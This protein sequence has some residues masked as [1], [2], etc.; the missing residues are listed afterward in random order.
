[1]AQ[2]LPCRQPAKAD[3]A[4]LYE[5]LVGELTD[6]VV[7][8]L[9]PNGCIVSWNPGVERILGYR[10]AEWLGQLADRIFTPEDR[11]GIPQQ[12]MTKAAR[13]G[14]APDVRWHVRKDGERLYVEGT[15]V[16]LRDQGGELLGFSKVMRDVTK[17]QRNEERNALLIRLDDATR[18]LID[19]GEIV[20]TAIHMLGEY[21][22]ADRC[23]FCEFHADQETVDITWDYLRPGV[24]SL[25]GRYQLAQ[26]GTVAGTL[27]RAGMPYVVEDVE[28]DIRISDVLAMYRQAEVRAGASVPLLKA[29]RL[30]AAVGVHQ[31]TPRQWRKDE[32]DLVGVVANRCWEAIE[33]ASITRALRESEIRFRSLVS[34]SSQVLYRMSP[35]W[36]EMR[37]LGGGGFIEDTEH[38]SVRWLE[39]YIDP[40][41]RPFVLSAITKAV[42]SKSIFELEHRVRR[43]DGSLGWTR[44]RA[45]PVFNERGAI[46]EWFGEATDIT[47]RK[48]LEQELR[49]SQERLQQ[50]FQQAPVAIAVYRGRDFVIEMANSS[51]APLLPGREDVIGRRLAD[52]A[53]D[54]GS[55]FWDTVH[56][57]L[58]TG[59]AFVANEFCVP[60]DQD[61][62]GVVENHWFNLVFHPLRDSDDSVSGIVAVSSEVTAQVRARQELER[63]NRELE[64]FA[65]VASHDLQEPLRMVNIYTQMLLNSPEADPELLQEYGGFVSGGVKRME[66]LIRDLLAYSRAVNQK[67]LPVGKADLS[68]SFHEAVSVLQNRI[69]ESGAIMTAPALPTVRGD[70]KQLTQVFQNLLAN[71]I[72]YRHPERVPEISVSTVRKEEQ[73][74]IA[75]QDNGI[76]FEPQY[77][78]QIFGLFK[79]LHKDEYPGTGLGLAICQRIIERYGGSLWAEAKPGEGAT[80]TFALPCTAEE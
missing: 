10:E 73:W 31:T 26:F 45:V 46:T 54:L 17:R 19:P 79:R 35:D 69:E 18:P 33:R 49:A 48:Q 11:A 15:M 7:F 78:E 50:V 58:D 77:A 44:S 22:G 8:L 43:V 36:T 14:R 76:G 72:K 29:G 6:F 34:A 16:A 61:G 62:D 20:Q 57:V 30:V 68:V 28:T 2:T 63:V 70:T 55:R 47:E 21:L 38:P 40:S 75:V 59:E 67:P 71:S 13:L 65:Y 12:E 41:D 51:F 52:V 27:L 5:M 74:I 53:P 3:K 32:V 24:L 42:K 25:R 56:G 66:G 37:Q 39:Q 9:D 80:F 4:Q 1:M 23:A 64:E 60:Y